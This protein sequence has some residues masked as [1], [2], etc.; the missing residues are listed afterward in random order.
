MRYALA[1]LMCWMVEK[2][3]IRFVISNC[4]WKIQS[5][6]FDGKPVIK[7][8]QIIQICSYLDVSTTVIRKLHLHDSTLKKAQRSSIISSE[9]GG[10][11]KG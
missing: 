5:F 8:G 11:G 7:I 1:E 10:N 6:L 9:T 2:F 4:W 3:D